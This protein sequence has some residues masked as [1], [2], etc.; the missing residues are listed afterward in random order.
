MAF[1]N[2][3]LA[4]GIITA[5]EEKGHITIDG[6]PNRVLQNDIQKLWRTSRVG[7]HMF[8]RNTRASITFPSFFALEVKFMLASILKADVTLTSRRTINSM[9]KALSEETW[10]GRIDADLSRNFNY[11]RLN[12]LNVKLLDHQLNFIHRYEKQTIQ[13]GLKG[14]YLAAAPGAGKT[15]NGLA[16]GLVMEADIHIMIV[17]KNAV[18]EVWVDNIERFFKVQPKLWHSLSGKPIDLDAKYFVCHYDQLKLLEPLIDRIKPKQHVFVNIDEGHNFNDIKSARTKMLID[19]CKRLPTRDVLWASGTPL[20]SIGSEVIPFLTTIDPYF[21]PFVMERF[22]KIF[23]MST[24]VAGNI[25]SHRIGEV[26]FKVGKEVIREAAP[27]VEEIKVQMPNGKNYTLEAIGQEMSN[28]ITERV[29]YYKDNFDK[30]NATYERIMDLHVKTI[31]NDDPDYY[32]YVHAVKT[33]K[34][35][36]DYR[37]VPDLLEYSNHYE[38]ELII[39]KLNSEDKKLFRSAKSVVK[40]VELKIRGEALGRILGR[41]RAECHADMVPYAR[42]PE[43]IEDSSSKTLIFTSFTEVVEEVEDYLTQGGEPCLT[44]YGKTNKDLKAIVANFDRNDKIRALAATLQSLST[45]VPMIMAS[46]VVF[47]NAP[48]RIHEREQAIARADRIGQVHQVRV[49]DVVLDTG[50][51]P[52]V[53]TRSTEIMEW[54]KEQVDLLMGK[55]GLEAFDTDFSES[56]SNMESSGVSLEGLFTDILSL[57]F[58]WLGMDALAPDHDDYYSNSDL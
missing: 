53:S 1:G 52:N 43:I 54:S 23:G 26:T 27:I 28:F 30:Y 44:V 20:K 32:R 34:G 22:K 48:F 37:E 33:L 47:M 25:L 9:I 31:D 56:L 49:Y 55:S 8:T 38:K 15:L 41:R 40:Y 29:K 42:L 50:T 57:P 19:F 18:E 13:Y 16:T 39:P 6:I 10:L 51:A 35:L 45:A 14:L 7:K 36:K 17:P 4:L 11:N 3:K 12:E 58:R 21:N 46:S 24:G 5:R 2:F